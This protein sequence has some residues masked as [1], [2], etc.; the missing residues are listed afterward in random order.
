M[1]LEGRAQKSGKEMRAILRAIVARDP[2]AARLAA[3]NHVRFASEAAA[4]AYA[5]EQ[6]KPSAA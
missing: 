5:V 6:K 3:T 4:K 1:S 2:E